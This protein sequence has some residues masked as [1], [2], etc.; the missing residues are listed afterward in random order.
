MSWKHTHLLVLEP[1]GLKILVFPPDGLFESITKLPRLFT[2]QTCF[3]THQEMSTMFWQWLFYE[4][5]CCASGVKFKSFS[6]ERAYESGWG[7]TSLKMQFD[8]PTSKQRN[9]V[10]PLTKVQIANQI[11]GLG[12]QLGKQWFWQKSNFGRIDSWEAGDTIYG[13][14][15]PSWAC[16]SETMTCVNGGVL[17]VL[18]SGVFFPPC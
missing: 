10:N 8:N 18:C 6:R 7:H 9:S 13:P 15:L 14:T 1:N 16:C 12:W 3:F 2:L 4:I 11:P 17:G 5:I